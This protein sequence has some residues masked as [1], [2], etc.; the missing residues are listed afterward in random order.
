MSGHESVEGL[1]AIVT[2]REVLPSSREDY[3]THVS[4][5]I[6][7]IKEGGGLTDQSKISRGAC[8][9]GRATHS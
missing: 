3:D 9:M 8:G 1:R 5:R 6:L 7:P 2:H 4:V